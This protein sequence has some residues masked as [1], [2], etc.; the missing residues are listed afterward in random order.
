MAVA[1]S[2]I[3]LDCLSCT[4]E[5]KLEYGCEEESPIPDK[6]TIDGYTFRRC[7]KKIVTRQSIQYIQAYKF[8]TLGFLPSPGAW[9]EQSLKFISA[10]EIIET[11]LLKIERENAEELKKL[12]RQ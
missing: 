11:E 1:L 7:P 8:F 3:R 10:V 12:K 9:L 2:R 5:M 4:A 6:W